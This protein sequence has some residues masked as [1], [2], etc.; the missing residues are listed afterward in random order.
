MHG[1]YLYFLAGA[2]VVSNAAMMAW[3]RFVPVEWA[4]DRLG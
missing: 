4:V 3:W 1:F 2:I